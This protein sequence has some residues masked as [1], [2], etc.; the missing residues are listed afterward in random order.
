MHE[1]LIWDAIANTRVEYNKIA[2][3]DFNK[4][5]SC[6]NEESIVIAVHMHKT[7][8]QYFSLFDACL[9]YIKR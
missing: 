9:N 2:D 4:F 5:S 6:F 8:K 3:L 7:R 1:S